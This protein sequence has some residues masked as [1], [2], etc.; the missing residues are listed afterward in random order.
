MCVAVLFLA[1][2]FETDVSTFFVPHYRNV[3]GKQV[4]DGR[5]SFAR[6]WSCPVTARIVVC[7]CLSSYCSLFSTFDDFSTTP[8]HSTLSY[9]I[10]CNSS[11]EEPCFTDRHLAFTIAVGVSQIILYAIGLPLIVFVFLWRHRDELDKPVVKFRYGL[12]FAGFRPETYYWE[13]IVALRKESTVLLAVFGPQMGV[14]MLAHVALLVFMVQVLVQLIGNPYGTNHKKL[15]ILDVG[16]ICICWGTMWSG[17]FFY[18][19]RP[20]EQKNAL[21]FLTM[22]VVLV[23]TLY[24]LILLYSMCFEACKEHED[25]SLVQVFRKRTSG[26][27]SLHLTRSQVRKRK[28]TV[29]VFNPVGMG[30]FAS[31]EMTPFSTERESAMDQRKN[32]DHLKRRQKKGTKTSRPEPLPD[33]SAQPTGA[34]IKRRER[35]LSLRTRRKSREEREVQEAEMEGAI[36]SD[37]EAKVHSNPLRALKKKPAKEAE[38]GAVS[39]VEAGPGIV[40]SISMPTGEGTATGS[41][42]TP[43]CMS[44]VTH[45]TF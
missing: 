31:I 43:T 20:P 32:A 36:F 26:L 8:S 9:S 35:L 14:A 45:S 2:E 21:V 24:M 29:H 27:S 12:F 30:H 4:F 19:P 28:G 18:T 7:R 39:V 15:Q 38:G 23:N 13:C 42:G 17:F 3:R 5:V 41:Y 40:E 6:F 16:A 10:P 34:H 11:F 1:N 44:P 22:V 25:N 33:A 37:A